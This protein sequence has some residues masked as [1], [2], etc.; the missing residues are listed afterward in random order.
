MWLHVRVHKRPA[1]APH[2]PAFRRRIPL[3]LTAEQLEQ[4]EH[5]QARYG[6]KRATLVAGIEALTRLEALE[7]ELAE[8]SSA[9]E[10]A[11]AR[12]AEFERKLDRAQAEADREKRKV[13]AAKKADQTSAGALAK[14]RKLTE[15]RDQLRR[16]FAAEHDERKRLEAELA[17]LEQELFDALCCARCGRLVPPGEWAV[18]EDEEG[19]LVYHERCGFHRGGLTGSTSV[20]G[21]RERR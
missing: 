13:T 10:E 12:A 20:L 14:A 18:R 5:A 2:P 17:E 16:A 4:L 3:E 21:V 19:D 1:E 15:E 6:T 9:C 11:L 8:R 7:Q